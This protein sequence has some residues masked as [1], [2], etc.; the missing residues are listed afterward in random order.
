MT[1]RRIDGYGTIRTVVA[2]NGDRIRLGTIK[3]VGNPRP[4]LWELQPEKPKNKPISG[5]I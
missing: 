5:G 3:L 1:Q 2:A 4:I